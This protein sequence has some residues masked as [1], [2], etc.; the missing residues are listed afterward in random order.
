M[1]IGLL[2]AN[3]FFVRTFFSSNDLNLDAGVFNALR[4]VLPILMI[5]IQ[6][7]TYDAVVDFFRYRNIDSLKESSNSE[8]SSNE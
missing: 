8:S 3:N 6:F 4:F 1:L 5:F 2:I 7:W